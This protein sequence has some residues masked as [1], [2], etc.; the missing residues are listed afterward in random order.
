M[1]AACGDGTTENPSGGVSQPPSDRSQQDPVHPLPPGKPGKRD[2]P[3]APR[4]RAA[5]CPAGAGNCS[6]AVGTVIY[7]ESVDPDGDGDLHVVAT[8]TRGDAVTGGG[9]VV[10]D[11]NKDLRPARD[12]RPGDVVT[13][14]GPVYR[15]SYG[16][17]Q[18]EVGEFR[19]ARR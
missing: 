10:F 1:P 9:L 12:P 4:I 7:I 19:V 15:G 17:R 13:G 8:V 14:A 16:Q 11:V 3:P 18:I 6:A 5:R 2:D